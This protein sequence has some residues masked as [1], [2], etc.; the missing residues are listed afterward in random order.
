MKFK[1]LLLCFFM[2]I[3]P[4]IAQE[5]NGIN[6]QYRGEREKVSDLVHTKLKVSFDFEKSQMPGEAWITGKIDPRMQPVLYKIGWK[7]VSGDAEKL[8]GLSEQS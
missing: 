8:L 4:M 2:S 6:P 3:G 1:V 7:Q 5:T